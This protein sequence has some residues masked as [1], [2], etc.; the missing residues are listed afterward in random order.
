MEI[1]KIKTECGWKR[2]YRKLCWF[3][4]IL[5]IAAEAVQSLLFNQRLYQIWVSSKNAIDYIMSLTKNANY[6]D[7][8]LKNK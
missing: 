5:S 2:V 4:N 6:V 3:Q 8:I 1:D 7:E